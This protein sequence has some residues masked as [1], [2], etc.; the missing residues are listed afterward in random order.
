MSALLSDAFCLLK[1]PNF[2]TGGETAR[3]FVCDDYAVYD[4]LRGGVEGVYAPY[5]KEAIDN[6]SKYIYVPSLD[7]PEKEIDKLID[8]VLSD[9]EVKLY[10]KC[11]QDLT[12]A[13][14]IDSRFGKSPVMLLH[15]FGL[16]DRSTVVSGV[17]LDKDDLSLMA[18]E[19]MP[20]I[21]LPSF[22]AGYGNGVAP[23][24]AALERGVKIKLG[25]ADGLY[26][27]SRSVIFEAVLLRLAVSAVMNRRDAVDLYSLAKMCA[28]DCADEKQIDSIVKLINI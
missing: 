13:G 23:V 9:S 16:S 3:T 1:R 12:E 18:Q 20:L 4:S 21:L 22:D 11:S 14:K 17:Y 6:R 27:K 19:G 28:C 2:G 7:L 15:E 10:V 24:V 5:A 25:T 8:Y 26:N